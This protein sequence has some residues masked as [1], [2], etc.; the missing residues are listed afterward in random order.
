MCEIFIVN[1]APCAGKTT[2]ENYVGEFIGKN[3]CLIISTIDPIKVI[4]ADLGWDGS[5]TPE[6]RKFLSDLKDMLTAWKDTSFKTVIELVDT[7]LKSAKKES[8]VFIDCREPKEIE[9]LKQY[10]NCKT[11]L[12]RR[13]GREEEISN[14]A[15]AEV[16]NYNYDI[17]IE[18]NGTKADLI[19]LVANFILNNVY[20]KEP[21]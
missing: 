12:V 16:E 8:V 13:E 19:D 2:F 17:V 15:D 3:N 9:R 14:H 5:K 18:N 10:Y 7:F 11:L 6:N 1:G 4:A 20:K 21:A